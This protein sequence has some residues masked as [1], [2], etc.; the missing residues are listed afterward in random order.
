[1]AK[2]FEEVKEYV[3]EYCLR[4]YSTMRKAEKCER[5]HEEQ[6]IKGIGYISENF[7]DRGDD[8]EG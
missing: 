5:S 2:Y 4:T 3:C 6:F 7:L 1:M 8:T